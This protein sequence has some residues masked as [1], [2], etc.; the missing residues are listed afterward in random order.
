METPKRVL[1]HTVSED[2]DEMLHDAAFHQGLHCLLKLKHLSG[3][4][5]HVH[6]NLDNST[7]PPSK[8][9]LSS[10]ILIALISGSTVAQW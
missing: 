7:F 3:T 9:I 6:H 4:R 5:I 1:C 2:P 8:N 10:P